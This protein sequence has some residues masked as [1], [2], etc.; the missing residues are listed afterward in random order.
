MDMNM[1]DFKALVK[2]HGLNRL[3]PEYHLRA[4]VRGLVADFDD[5]TYRATTDADRERLYCALRD[6]IG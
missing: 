6:A 4:V 5:K 2:R 1:I 3:S